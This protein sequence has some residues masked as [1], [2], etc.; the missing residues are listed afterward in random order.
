[1]KLLRLACALTVVLALAL[2]VSA[3]AQVLERAT[4][5]GHIMSGGA[6]RTFSFNAVERAGGEVAGH[7]RIK[8]RAT[9]IKA[10]GTVECV[11]VEGDTAFLS[12]VITKHTIAA[13]VGL[14]FVVVVQD[15]GEGANN[16]DMISLTFQYPASVLAPTEG[17]LEEEVC[18]CVL[19][20]LQPVRNGNVQVWSRAARRP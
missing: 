15:N 19:E 18:L 3:Q 16:E 1:M 12:G 9:G 20:Q 10:F 6:L 2:P 8:A 4:G 5:S 7:I 13:R 11:R 14:T 17:C